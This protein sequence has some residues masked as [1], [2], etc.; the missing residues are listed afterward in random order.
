MRTHRQWTRRASG[1][2]AAGRN[3][4]RPSR[5]PRREN[6]AELV[7]RVR[8]AITRLP[9]SQQRIV[10]LRDLEGPTPAEVCRILEQTEGNQ[11]VLLHRG[12][13]R[14]RA[15]LEQEVATP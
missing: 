13:A 12:R 4:A 8:A 6:D 9:E 14:I 3:R 11:R 10:T 15:I 7:E 2:T 5:T 1:R